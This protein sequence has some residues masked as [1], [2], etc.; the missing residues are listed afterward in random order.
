MFTC[1][2]KGGF[3]EAAEPSFRIVCTKYTCSERK[4]FKT[5]NI[6]FPLIVRDCFEKRKHKLLFVILFFSFKSITAL[7]LGE[8]YC[9][10][11]WKY[12]SQ[13]YPETLKRYFLNFFKDTVY[14]EGGELLSSH[15]AVIKF[16]LRIFMGGQNWN[17]PQGALD[18]ARLRHWVSNRGGFTSAC[19][20]THHTG[21][22]QNCNSIQIYIQNRGILSLQVD[23]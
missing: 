14:R 23:L 8:V 11:F 7:L 18:T 17:F 9:V 13:E 20:S 21:F 16:R 2:I 10:Y 4:H 12:P 6:L 19:H 3:T 15:Y 5:P 1:I 22:S